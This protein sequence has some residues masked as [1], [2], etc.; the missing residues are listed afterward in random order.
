[1]LLSMADGQVHKGVDWHY[2]RYLRLFG[3]PL[4]TQTET[5]HVMLGEV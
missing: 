5:Q 4:A 2:Q 1:V 3:S